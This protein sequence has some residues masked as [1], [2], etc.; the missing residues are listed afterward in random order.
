MSCVAGDVFNL[1]ATGDLDLDGDDPTP[2]VGPRGWLGD[3]IGLQSA[4]RG[5][6]LHAGALYVGDASLM[7][8]I[9]GAT[10]ERY[11][12]FNDD[13]TA[14]HTCGEAHDLWLLIDDSDTTD[15]LGGYDVTIVP[16][17]RAG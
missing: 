15:N 12:M 3:E 6:Y 8:D 17:Q 10:I 7:D 5:G 16:E 14:R 9:E 13:G 2:R 1:K 4:Y 11:T